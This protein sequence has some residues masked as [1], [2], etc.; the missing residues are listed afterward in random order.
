MSKA[1]SLNLAEAAAKADA[2]ADVMTTGT[3][4]IGKSDQVLRVKR[5]D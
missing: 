3:K 1:A 5:L 2:R 4:K